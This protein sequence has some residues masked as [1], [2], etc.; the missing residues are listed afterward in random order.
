M[1]ELHTSMSWIWIAA[2]LLACGIIIVLYRVRLGALPSIYR[3]LILSSRSAFLV[4]TLLLLINPELSWSRR[5]SVPPTI[6]IFLD[7]SLSMANH[8]TAAVSTIFT[9]VKDVVTWAEESEYQPEIFTFGETLERRADEH[10]KYVPD[11]RI[12][13][14][15]PL[16]PY[17]GD[18]QLQ[19]IFLFSDGVV[20]SGMEPGAFAGGTETP[21]YTVGIGDT[22]RNVDLSILDV[23]YPLTM[24][25]QERNDL[26]VRIRAENAT[27]RR[28]RLFV[29]NEGQLIRT[30]Q[31]SFRSRESIQ[32]FT[33]SIV[34]RLEAGHFRIELMVLPEEINIDNNRR[35]F[36]ID[37]LPGQR[38]IAQVTGGLSSNTSFINRSLRGVKH[39]TVE[40]LVF[41]KGVW[42]GDEAKF[43]N[44]RH[45]L[46]ILDNYPTTY[47]PADH[48]DR[49]LA[50]LQRDKPAILL[51]EGPDN[52]NRDFIRL[53]R[54]LGLPL[55]VHDNLGG[56]GSQLAPIFPLPGLNI[57]SGRYA[58]ASRAA[59]PEVSL[60]HAVDM[61]R[62]LNLSKILVD[63]DL[64]PAAAY[65]ILGGQKRAFFLLPELATTHMMLSRTNW[66]NYLQDI[67]GA[68]IEWE[69]EPEGFSPY[70]LQP[71]KRHYHLGEKVLLRGIM[72]DRAGT[73]MLQPVLSVEIVGPSSSKLVPLSYD[74]DSG[75]YE[76]EFWPGDPGEYK[77]R[78]FQDGEIAA[79]A[80]ETR[81]QVLTGRIELESITQNRYSLE[82]LSQSSGGSHTDLNGVDNLLA[83]L[84]YQPELVMR[85]HHF[86]LW[87]V[88][89]IWVVL[90]LVL[91]LEW[92]VRRI[93]G[94]I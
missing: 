6:G 33:I 49:L 86:S 15:D 44:T 3:Y 68:L 84:T 72:R 48:L 93:M 92:T 14:F 88:W 66:P 23:N 12:T 89:Y 35:E 27:G 51:V 91:G 83:Q 18:S 73:K 90:V 57:Q 24:L 52:N 11:E 74:F 94:L 22:A 71:D 13:E 8:P 4:V 77:I 36:E 80:R 58:D 56:R 81:F 50:K 59:F 28:S 1:L 65:G 53:F 31:I 61:Q 47:L 43:W 42:Q 76:G 70:I 30:E 32:S 29:F 20:T 46:I 82:R 2:G 41:L 17:L 85:E 78:M 34:G 87:Q 10:F 45:D 75:E 7:N 40:H 67:M 21:I 69:L 79:T 37:V 25:D 19:A 64:N 26:T 62:N 54:A 38:Q 16:L 63:D 5:V 9:K 39:A 60:A 55:A